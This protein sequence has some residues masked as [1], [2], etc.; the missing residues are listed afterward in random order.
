MARKKIKNPADI[1]PALDRGTMSED[2]QRRVV[3]MGPRALPELL[4]AALDERGILATDPATMLAVALVDAIGLPPQ[5][6]PRALDLYLSLPATA[7]A[8]PSLGVMVGSAG[9]E[10]WELALARTESVTSPVLA[11]RLGWVLAD[12]KLTGTQE[13]LTHL[14]QLAPSRMAWVLVT[15]A[16]PLLLPALDQALAHVSVP[17]D[18]EPQLY[19]ALFHLVQKARELGADAPRCLMLMQ[20]LVEQLRELATEVRRRRDELDG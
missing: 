7:D 4:D 19:D 6:A 15:R 13:A 11:A 10:A 5:Q 3:Q 18:A 20:A 12:S 1:R 2:E 16:D 8:V 9:P 17:L 14:T